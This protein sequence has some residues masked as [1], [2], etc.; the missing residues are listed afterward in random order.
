MTNT[1]SG[2]IRF[3][4]FATLVRKPLEP[5]PK[6]LIENAKIYYRRRLERSGYKIRDDTK[7][8]IEKVIEHFSHLAVAQNGNYAPPEKGLFIYGQ[9]GTGKSM[10]LKRLAAY[11]IV[12]KENGS[13]QGKYGGFKMIDCIT[14]AHEYAVGGFAW[15]R[16]NIKEENDSPMVIDELGGEP[17]IQHYGNPPVIPD[18]LTERYEA[19]IDRGITTVFA[20]NLTGIQ[21][22]PEDLDSE[23]KKKKRV[24]VLYGARIASRISEMCEL[25]KFVGDDWRLK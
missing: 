3:I 2:K 22:R 5:P 24:E 25:V 16:D 8:G 13:I 11:E 18:V 19:F 21:L 1:N 4:D 7:G 6:E 20:T 10:L 12:Y 23:A 14:I 9:C 17:Q 15:F